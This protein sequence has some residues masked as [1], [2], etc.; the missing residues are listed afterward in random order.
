MSYE[1][2]V[3]ITMSAVSLD[4]HQPAM[5]A[6]KISALRRWMHVKMTISN[7]AFPQCPAAVRLL[8]YP[9]EKNYCE[10]VPCK[11]RRGGTMLHSHSD[12]QFWDKKLEGTAGADLLLESGFA[13][14]W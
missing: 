11:S 2:R 1:C 4:G 14:I 3:T 13:D 7:V 5:A 10:N 8:S 12:V 9:A 6:D